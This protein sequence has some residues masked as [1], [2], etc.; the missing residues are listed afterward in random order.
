MVQGDEPMVLVSEEPPRPR[1]T[2]D[3]PILGKRRGHNL[4][5]VDGGSIGERINTLISAVH[6]IVDNVVK[7]QCKQGDVNSTSAV[8][9]RR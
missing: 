6:E 3:T 5:S 1:S 2:H 7:R 4:S 8:E 9:S